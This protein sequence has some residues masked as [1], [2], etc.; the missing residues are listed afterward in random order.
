ML[1]GRA[2]ERY[3]EFEVRVVCVRL[4]YHFDAL[5]FLGRDRLITDG[6]CFVCLGRCGNGDEKQQEDGPEK[7]QGMLRHTAHVVRL[8]QCGERP[9]RGPSCSACA[10]RAVRPEQPREA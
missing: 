7:K 10:L 6:L 4:E 5:E 9:G 1:D 8:E 3:D 2:G